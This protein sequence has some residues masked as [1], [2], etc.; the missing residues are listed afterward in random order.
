[1][2]FEITT[3]EYGTILIT[4]KSVAEARSIANRFPGHT[5]DWRDAIEKEKKEH[6]VS[7]SVHA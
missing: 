6:A 3:R 7:C 5:R 4:A 2:L 1:M